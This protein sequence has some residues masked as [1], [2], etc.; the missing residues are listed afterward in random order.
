MWF[1]DHPL[2][3]ILIGVVLGVFVGGAWTATGRKELL[4]ALGAVVALTVAWLAVE[5]FVVTD[6]EAVQ[7]TLAEI[8]RDVQ[9]NNMQKVLGHI[10]KG[11]PSL[12]ARAQAEMPN[13]QFTEC[14]ITKIHK[15]DID[16][17][18]EPRSALVE[19]NVIVTGAFSQGGFE[20]SG[21]YARWVQ[22]QLIREAD[23]KWRVQN[24]D[25]APPQEFLFGE[26]LYESDK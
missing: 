8:A 4:Y 15:T 21:R 22:L 18:S 20:A 1:L 17:G 10:A 23:G 19:F 12:V 5:R 16:A 24:Y 13:Y 7:A 9:A 26:P 6:R 14:R 25:H 3:I 11:N 2:S